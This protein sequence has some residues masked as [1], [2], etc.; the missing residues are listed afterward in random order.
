M[1]RLAEVKEW[2]VRKGPDRNLHDLCRRK[3]RKGI[4]STKKKVETDYFVFL[5]PAA[6]RRPALHMLGRRGKLI[7]EKE[8]RAHRTDMCDSVNSANH[9]ALLVLRGRKKGPS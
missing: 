3:K 9:Q 1:I 6:Q 4:F 2:K 5:Q 8:E 7:K